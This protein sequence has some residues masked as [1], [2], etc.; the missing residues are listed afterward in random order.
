MDERVPPVAHSLAEDEYLRDFGRSEGSL[1]S[2][3]LCEV[4]ELIYQ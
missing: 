2:N 3:T 4:L 1:D